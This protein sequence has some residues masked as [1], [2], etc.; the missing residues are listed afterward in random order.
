MSVLTVALVAD[1]VLKATLVL[2]LAGL[3]AA[4]LGRASAATR[5]LVWTLGVA[6][7]LLVP[8]LRAAAPRWELPLLPATPTVV[9]IESPAAPSRGRSHLRGANGAAPGR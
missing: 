6:A 8:A 1:V 4:A 9:R 5:H 7:A 2:G 3:A